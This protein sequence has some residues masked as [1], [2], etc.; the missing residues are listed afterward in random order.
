VPYRDEPEF[1]AGQLLVDKSRAW[2]ALSLALH[3]NEHSDFY[4]RYFYGDKDTFH[5]AWRRLEQEYALIPYPLIDTVGA[6]VIYQHDFEG[7][8]IFQHRN[9]DKWGMH[10][11]NHRIDGFAHEDTCLGFIDELRD[12]WG[13]AVRHIPDEF[14][15]VERAAFDEIVAT[16]AFTYRL[17]G[18]EE[19]VLELLPDFSINVGWA[20]MERGWMVEEDKDG[21]P[22]LIIT[23]DGG[24]TCFLRRAGNGRWHGSWRSYERHAVILEPAA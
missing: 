22:L 24:I 6:L 9:C 23:N 19:R 15:R 18:A 10:G 20:D 4:Y 5:L 2:H 3:Y 14:T 7:R 16:R 13:G 8:I 12:L 21:K 17:I 1:E 11:A